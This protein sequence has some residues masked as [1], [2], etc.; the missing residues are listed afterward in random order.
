MI[1][2]I[3]QEMSAR[4][5]CVDVHASGGVVAVAG[6]ARGELSSLLAAATESEV[7]GAGIYNVVDSSW[8]VRRRTIED[9]PWREHDANKDLDPKGNHYPEWFENLRQYGDHLS[10]HESRLQVSIPDP[11]FRFQD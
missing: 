6:V 3:L 8:R 2:L 4:L 10:G 1:G 5:G 7:C 11:P 9:R